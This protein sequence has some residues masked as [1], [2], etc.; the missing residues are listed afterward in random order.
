MTTVLLPSDHPTI[1]SDR[2]LTAGHGA[3]GPLYSVVF[4]WP[5][6]EVIRS[7]RLCLM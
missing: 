7:N 4:G 5:W 3:L 2:P 1:L 6:P